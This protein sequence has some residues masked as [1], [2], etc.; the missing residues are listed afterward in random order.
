MGLYQSKTAKVRK[1]RERM[2]TRF[3][4]YVR[5]AVPEEWGGCEDPVQ[6]LGTLQRGLHPQ[7]L[8]PRHTGYDA[9]SGGYD[10]G[11]DWEGDLNKC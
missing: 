5:N 4:S 3:A 9:G 1:H 11:C 10:G 7:H 6:Y 8:H 2:M